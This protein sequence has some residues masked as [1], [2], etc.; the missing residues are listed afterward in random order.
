MISLNQK[1]KRVRPLLGTFVS[2][3]LHGEEDESVLNEY[4]SAGFDAISRVHELMSFHRAESDLSRLNAADSHQW[5]E[6]DPAVREV[7]EASNELFQNSDGLFD[8][9]CGGIL[10]ERGILP[11]QKRDPAFFHTVPVKIKGQRVQ[12]TGNWI[13][14][15][16]GIAKGYAVDCAVRRIQHLSLE[17]NMSGV[18]NAGGDMFVWGEE[19]QPI[20]TRILGNAESWL[21]SFR[22]KQTAVATSSVRTPS[23]MHL[24]PSA[25]VV[26]PGRNFLTKPKTVTVLADRCLIADAL[27]KIV[28]LAPLDMARRCLLQYRAKAVLFKPDGT[29]EK[30]VE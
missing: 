23:S 12:K 1:V 7:L 28:L 17:K 5:I 30:I 2:I 4:I 15:L 26:M 14:D 27:T 13:L 16:G 20:A 10:V 19:T 18:V 29:F 21:Q 24:A 25:H 6:L 22:I 9:R 3:E 11:G 8:I